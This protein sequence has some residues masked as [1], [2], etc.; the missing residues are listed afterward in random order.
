MFSDR[1]SPRPGEGKCRRR[2]QRRATEGRSALTVETALRRFAEEKGTKA[3]VLIN[4]A[5]TALTGQSVGPG[6]F[7]VFLLMGRDR[8]VARLRRAGEIGAQ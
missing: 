6:M 5:R 7:E 3:G 8:S 1:S 4:A 2:R